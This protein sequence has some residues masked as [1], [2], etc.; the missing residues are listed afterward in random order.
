MRK[1]SICILLAALTALS[2][3]GCLGDRPAP[4]PEPMPA[5]TLPPTA[6]PEP[7]PSPTATPAPTPTPA[8]TPTP[9]PTATPE[10]TPTPTPEPTPVPGPSA[11]AP[12]ISKQ[13]FGETQY[14]GST[15]TFIANANSYTDVGWRAVM[16]DG[17]D[18]SMETFQGNFPAC[19]VTGVYSNT[20][21]IGN[22]S[23]DMNG[24]SF[25]CVFG[26]SG[27]LVIT[28]KAALKVLGQAA[29]AQK[30][31]TN[32]QNAL[33]TAACP[34]CGASIPAD[35]SYCPSCGE[36]INADADF[37]AASFCPHC[38]SYVPAGTSTCPHC[39]ENIYA[40]TGSGSTSVAIVDPGETVAK[41]YD[42]WFM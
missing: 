15:A 39:G 16:P 14:T 29:P 42:T 38:G 30:A 5:I 27:T 7:T 20:L 19:T 36:Y 6:T 8:A 37:S 33:A 41:D 25:Y 22:L 28:N 21:A 26:N 18:V 34:I 9:E 3:T 24:W 31:Q 40:S 1:R 35:V 11:P 12:V 13:P 23:P 17:Q 4:T 2:L 32:T 10:P